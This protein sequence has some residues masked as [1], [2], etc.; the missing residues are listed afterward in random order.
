MR[1]PSCPVP[2]KVLGID[3]EAVSVSEVLGFFRAHHS[4]PVRTFSKDGAQ[5]PQKIRASQILRKDGNKTVDLGRPVLLGKVGSDL[6][7]CLS[8][9]Q[10]R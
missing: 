9:D 6:A 8:F 1:A 5:F 4:V 2:A 10:I 3:P 7:K